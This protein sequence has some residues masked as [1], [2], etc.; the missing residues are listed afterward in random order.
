MLDTSLSNTI[1]QRHS[2]AKYPQ[3]EVY[4]SCP[5]LCLCLP[6]FLSLPLFSHHYDI[7]SAH[8]TSLTGRWQLLVPFG[9]IMLT[10]TKSGCTICRKKPS[11]MHLLFSSPKPISRYYPPRLHRLQRIRMLLPVIGERRKKG[12]KRHWRSFCPIPRCFY[13]ARESLSWSC[14]NFA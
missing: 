12:D 1:V 6:V 3:N 8:C 13:I 5:S 14:S 4:L 11:H 10:D 9:H 7:V 2:S